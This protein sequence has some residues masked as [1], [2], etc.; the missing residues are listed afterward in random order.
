L[1]G[2]C[3]IKFLT[4]DDKDSHV[5]FW[6]S[7]AHILGYALEKVF[8]SRLCIGPPL[9]NGFYYDCYLGDY[10]I[11]EKDYA[12]IEKSALDLIKKNIKFERLVITKDEALELFQYNEFKTQ[13]IQN[14]VPDNSLTSAYRCGD[15]IDLCL[16][17][18]LPSTGKVKAFKVMKHSASY[19][20][21]KTSNDSLQRVYGTS[22]LTNE[23]LKTYLFN[24]E[25][26]KK[27]D[28]RKI[29]EEQKLFMHNIMS[30]GSAFF[31]PNGA[32]M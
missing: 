20:L 4:W 19:W 23:E 26:A 28:H 7:S 17:P 5:V 14:K 8:G 25:E 31:L 2:D 32:S 12:E 15:F 10:H 29:G 6:H 22:F 21:G 16:G 11:Q 24:L 27:R 13:L 1:E 3:S 18:H 9:E 30:P